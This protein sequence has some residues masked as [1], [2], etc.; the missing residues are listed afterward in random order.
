MI[1]FTVVT[2]LDTITY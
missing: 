2:I 1:I